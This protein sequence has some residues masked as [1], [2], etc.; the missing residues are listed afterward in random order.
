[1]PLEFDAH[2]SEKLLLRL[3]Q[4]RLLRRW[5][6]LLIAVALVGVGLVL[7]S[8][9]EHWSAV[10]IMG[11]TV[12]ALLLFIYAAVYVKQMRALA[13]WKRM[14]GDAPVHYSLSE[15]TVHARSNLGATELKWRVFRK[16]VEWPDSFLLYYSSDNHLTLPREEVPAEVVDFIRQKFHELKLP[17]EKA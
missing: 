7:D 6:R 4:R 3:T 10:S 9:S 16:L 2:I 5:P 12:M 11:V 15:E 8:R 17:V 13:A 14:Q 1:M